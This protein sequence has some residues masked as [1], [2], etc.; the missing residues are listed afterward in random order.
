MYELML[1]ATIAPSV[2]ETNNGAILIMHLI[3]NFLISFNMSC[4]FTNATAPE[5]LQSRAHPLLKEIFR[6]NHEIHDHGKI[7][8]QCRVPSSLMARE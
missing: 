8:F 7:Y 1:Y 3:A 4:T 2:F 6:T 5:I